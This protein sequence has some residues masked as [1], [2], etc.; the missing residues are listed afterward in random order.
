MNSIVLLAA[1]TVYNTITTRAEF[2]FQAYYS[3][4]PQIRYSDIV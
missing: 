1:L 2:V 4:P 3:R